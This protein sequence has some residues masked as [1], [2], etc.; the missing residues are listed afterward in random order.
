MYWQ[1]SLI[2]T[3]VIMKKLLAI[4]LSG[5]V[6]VSC[7]KREIQHSATN[8][9]PSASS[10]SEISVPLDF[11]WSSSKKGALNVTV[12][13]PNLNVNGTFLYLEDELG[14]VVDRQ[15]IA[16]NQASFY[17]SIPQNGKK[18][19]AFHRNTEQSIEVTNGGNVT[20]S[21]PNL[22]FE[23]RL[24]TDGDNPEKKGKNFWGSSKSKSQ[25]NVLVNGDFSSTSYSTQ[26]GGYDVL[27]PVGDWY[28]YGSQGD[29][30]S[31]N[32]NNKYKSTGNSYTC[33]FQSVAVT[34]GDSFCFSLDYYST[35]TS[36]RSF[37]I[38]YFDA[39]QNH[40]GYFSTNKSWGTATKNGVVPANAA[41]FQIYISLKKYAYV[42]DVVL[43]IKASAPDADNDGVADAD[44]DYPNDPAKA[45]RTNFPTTG[46]QSV[47]FEDLWPFQGDFDMN[48][49]VIS[50]QVEYS[51]DANNNRVDATFTLSLEAVGA[52]F[53]NGLAMVFTDANRQPISQNIIASVSGD[54]S[55]DPNVTNGVIIFNNVFN[56]QSTY[57]QNNG[58]GPNASPD[59]F[60]FTVTFNSN[61]GSQ[62]IVPD[63]YLFRTDDRGLEIHLDGFSGTSQANQAYF[64]TGDDLNG[65]YSTATGLPWAIEV[66]TENNTYKHPLE[67]VDIL[68]AYPQFQQWAES[69]GS[70]NTN[71]LDVPVIG[72]IFQ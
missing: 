49:M 15:E 61:A 34:P 46:Y 64:N 68:L 44:D 52:S 63:I 31:V 42:D 27:R 53:K 2:T 24:L 11:N 6:F 65:T 56:A 19:F 47:S 26:S 13:A 28:Q 7:S 57:Y 41:Y 55:T 3:F 30:L 29:I 45:Y 71:W 21:V 36:Y 23:Q 1:Q 8:N 43:D 14:N 60:S 72:N 37:Y 33:I 16:N 39:N 40:I 5:F 62:S 17:Y 67:K 9:T 32:G 48:D 59:V 18:L 22:T 66:V 50:N 4:T 51:A 12:D 38:D 35:K 10:L 25:A 20:L 69:S 70:Q 58:V 54:A